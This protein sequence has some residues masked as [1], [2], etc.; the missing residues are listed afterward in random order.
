MAYHRAL[1]SNRHHHLVGWLYLSVRLTERS[2]LAWDRYATRRG[3]TLTTLAEAIGEHLDA[4]QDD[5]VPDSVITRARELDRQ[6]RS[7]R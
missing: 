4:G 2:R 6:R 3:V 5:W 7:R 1:T